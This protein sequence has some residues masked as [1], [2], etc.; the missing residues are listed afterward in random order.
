MSAVAGVQE[1]G[2]GVVRVVEVL[3]G[4]RERAGHGQVPEHVRPFQEVEGGPAGPGLAVAQC[5]GYQCSRDGRLDLGYGPVGA[6]IDGG[7][8]RSDGCIHRSGVR[9]AR[10]GRCNGGM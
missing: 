10:E 5:D 3:E 4:R 9:V 2:D 6:E 1:A 7:E 8:P